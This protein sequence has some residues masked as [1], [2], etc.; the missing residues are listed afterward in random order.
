VHRRLRKVQGTFRPKARQ[1]P[2]DELVLTVLSQH[3][4]DVNSARAFAGLRARF[5]AWDEVLAAPDEDVAAA[6]RPG[7]IANIKARRIQA[8]LAEVERRE[9]AL[10]LDR[11]QHVDDAEAE[12]YLC[13]LPGV[14]PKTAAC[15]LLFA[16]GRPAFP[17]DTHVHRV[18]TRLGLVPARAPAAAAHAQLARSVPPELRHE[19][20][21]QLVRHGREVCRARTPRCSVCVLF[22]VC[23]SG[24]RLLAAGEAR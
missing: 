17:V 22:D 23:E 20:H 11:L 13:S 14:G 15:V 9:G 16:L 6:I 10:T 21:V 3:T 18:A 5:D 7:G 24:P 2:L 12:G 1:P 4:S 8:I 19:L